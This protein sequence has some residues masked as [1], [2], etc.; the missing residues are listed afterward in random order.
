MPI[1]L[2]TGSDQENYDL[3]TKR[4]Q[5]LFEVFHHKVIGGSDHEVAHGKPEPDIFLV[6]ARRFSD[7]PDPSKVMFSN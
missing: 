3:K 5:D 4:W 6:A 2:G 1:A 7:N